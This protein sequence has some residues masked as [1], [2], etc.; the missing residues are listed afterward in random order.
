MDAERLP[1]DQ[2]VALARLSHGLIGTA[3]TLA[4]NHELVA[5]RRR[6]QA[7]LLALLERG[8][9]DRFGSIRDLLEEAGRHA[10]GG[11]PVDRDGAADEDARVSSAAQRSAAL[12]LTSVWLDLTRDLI[13]TAAGEADLA[14]GTELH[15]D[16]PRVASRLG[17]PAL[18]SFAALLERIR[19]GLEQN[20]APRL[21]MEVAMLEWPTLASASG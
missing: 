18:A 2:A 8:R 5:W 19:D 7:E 4:Q 9:A 6:T 10:A 17:I 13:V 12:L 16:L 15:A 1:E 11:P 3:A 14:A 20:A 21:A